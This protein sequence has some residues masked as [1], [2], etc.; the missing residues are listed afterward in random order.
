VKSPRFSAIIRAK[1]GAK[2][3]VSDRDPDDIGAS[4]TIGS[5]H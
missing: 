4:A 5:W 1:S 2:Q 3:E